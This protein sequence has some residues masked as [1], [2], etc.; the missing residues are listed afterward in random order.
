MT[1]PAG[2][3]LWFAAIAVL[4]AACIGGCSAE[5]PTPGPPAAASVSPSAAPSSA[6]PA[7]AAPVGAAVDL[8]ATLPVKG[9]APMTGYDRT[10]DFG[11]AW[12][13]VDRNGC[14]TRDDVLARDLTSVARSGPCRVVTGTLVSPY[15]L[16]RIDFVR[17]I[18]TSELVQID[19]LVS[20]GDAWQTGAQSIPQEQSIRLA[21]D[22]L[23]LLAVDGRSNQQKG[24]GDAATWLPANKSFRCEYVARQISVK[25]VYRLW[26]TAAEKAAM[27]GILSGCPGQTAYTSTLAP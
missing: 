2:R 19:H 21:N 1:R 22:P 8:L 25:A 15:T 12:L 24:D 16:Q 5:F 20:L 11:S 18:R 14:D 3:S 27:L 10:G 23:N 13:D 26:V 9:R 6:A 17:G 4:A 7:S